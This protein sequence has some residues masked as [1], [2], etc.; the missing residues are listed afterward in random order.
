M[1]KILIVGEQ[2]IFRSIVIAEFLN[3]ILKQKEKNDFDVKSAGVFAMMDIPAEEG[4]KEELKKYNINGDF[5]SKPLLK[6]DVENADF[7]LTIN[8][9]IK[10]AILNKFPEKKDFIYTVK[11]F[12]GD[13]DKD[14]S[15]TKITA[16]ETIQIINKFVDKL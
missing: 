10:N 11:E 2:N 5:Y 8:S 12:A 1:K 7:I 16:E 3:F 9:K 6:Q 13:T 15:E 14:I 4:A